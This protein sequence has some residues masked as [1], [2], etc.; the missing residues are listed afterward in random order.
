MASQSMLKIFYSENNV[1]LGLSAKIHSKFTMRPC[2]LGVVMFIDF[3]SG[4]HSF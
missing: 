1:L 2:Y 3:I 4:Y